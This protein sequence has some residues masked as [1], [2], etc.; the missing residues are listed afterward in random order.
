MVLIYQPPNAHVQS[1]RILLGN[2]MAVAAVKKIYA[3]LLKSSFFCNDLFHSCFSVSL[4][5]AV[6]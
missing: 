1:L 6:S 3:Y 2:A 5:I 4:Q